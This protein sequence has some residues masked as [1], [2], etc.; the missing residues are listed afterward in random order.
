M[1]FAICSLH[2]AWYSLI[3]ELMRQTTTKTLAEV[4]NCYKAILPQWREVRF[5][6]SLVGCK[7]GTALLYLHKMFDDAQHWKVVFWV[8]LYITLRDVITSFE[9]ILT[10]LPASIAMQLVFS[11]TCNLSQFCDMRHD[12]VSSCSWS[13]DCVQHCGC[14]IS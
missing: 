12:F 2:P 11:C 5:P 9:S 14:W 10:H 13:T 6:K 1:T 3:G 8:F 4:I 7:N